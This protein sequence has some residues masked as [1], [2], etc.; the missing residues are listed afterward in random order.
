M[1]ET[2]FSF[3]LNT[4]QRKLKMICCAVL[5]L[6]LPLLAQQ[7]PSIDIDKITEKDGFL[8]FWIKCLENGKPKEGLQK[9][10]FS[11][12]EIGFDSIDLNPFGIERA[13]IYD[14]LTNTSAGA[15]ISFL[16]D[17]SAEMAPDDLR[18]AKIWIKDIVQERTKD[19][20]GSEF[21]LTAFSDKFILKQEELNLQNV[22]AILKSLNLSSSSADFYRPLIQEIKFLKRQNG[23][24]TLFIF[25]TGANTINEENYQTRL[26]YE[27]SDVERLMASLPFNFHTFVIVLND[28]P[29]WTS[30]FSCIRSE[31]T[32]SYKGRLPQDYPQ[33][34]GN[35]KKILSN[36]QISV[37]PGN[38]NFDGQERIYRV[39]L[40]NQKTQALKKIRL[41]TVNFPVNIQRKTTWT[42]WVILLALGIITVLVILG[43]GS[44]IV[45]F[46][47]EKNFIKKY[48]SPYIPENKIVRYDL[49]YNDP[50]EQ[51][52]MVVK[53][54]RQI[55][56]LDSWKANEWQCPNYP[57]CLDQ[58]CNGAGAP[59]SNSFF[60]M[61]GVYLKLNWIWF[62]AIGGLLAWVIISLFR[63]TD[64][65]GLNQLI[66]NFIG[67]DFLRG[68]SQN[69]PELISRTISSNLLVGVAF[70]TGLL[71]MLSWMEEKRASNRYS[72][73]RSVARIGMRTVAG[74][75]LSAVA[76]FLGF[77]LQYL[78]GVSPYLSGL[79]SWLLFGLFIG[80]IMSI[81][82]S[83]SATNGIIGGTLAAVIAF[84]VYFGLS[85]FLKLG[86]LEANLVSMILMGG[87]VGS[88]LVSVV[89]TLED[90]ELEV[91]APPGYQRTVPI[92]K[93]LKSNI[94][95]MIGKSPGCY[96]YI[97]W[98]DPDV[99]PEHAELFTE[100]GV[101]FLRPIEEVLVNQKIISK[102]IPLKNGDTIQ[103]GRAGLTRFR[104][105][106]K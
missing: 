66:S 91:I 95:V 47:R 16:L 55:T 7:G 69:N 32:Y 49:Y 19:S 92:S 90:Y 25:G 99:R 15:S 23:T 51:G 10:D 60:S 8:Y 44:L 5:L 54:C 59:E 18:Q 73:L 86:F 78:L 77:Y 39:V 72:L 21:H 89:T 94:G 48:V 50:I 62:G 37:T 103:L 61:E 31:T 29:E 82:S 106:E 52:E 97:K 75:L 22:D 83:I 27:S 74:I 1:K 105:V 12:A 43:V 96:I 6:R 98:D 33:I 35:N 28:D 80:I 71:M 93:W 81:Y 9:T 64:F 42:S 84:Q 88:I 3:S 13:L 87:L 26:P 56:P 101:V 41:G 85:Q 58:N 30:N 36:Y 63:M 4:L 2:N 14:T 79:L 65:Q 70:G 11:F 104:F 76:F 68:I 57:V 40:N 45:P 38:P 24:K 67:A 34:L 100:N 102:P 20:N 17:L 53:K 46:I